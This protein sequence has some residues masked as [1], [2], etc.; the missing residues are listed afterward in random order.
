MIATQH[1]FELL[2][3]IIGGQLWL[4]PYYLTPLEA[5]SYCLAASSFSYLLSAVKLSRSNPFRL[6][7]LIES[8]KH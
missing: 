2:S 3:Q 6:L 5:V 8:H 7:L 1:D 4:S